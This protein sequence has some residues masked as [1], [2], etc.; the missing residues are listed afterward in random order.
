MPFTISGA[1]SEMKAPTNAAWRN[2]TLVRATSQAI[3]APR[4]MATS[5]VPAANAMVTPQRSNPLMSMTRA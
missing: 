4:K 2:A 3:D 5:D 1:E